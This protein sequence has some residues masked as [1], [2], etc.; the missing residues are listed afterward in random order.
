MIVTCELVEIETSPGTKQKKQKEN[1]KC[2]YCG[3]EADMIID[4]DE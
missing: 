2:T 4:F 1:R 3:N